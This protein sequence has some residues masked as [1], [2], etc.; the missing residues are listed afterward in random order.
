VTQ[1]LAAAVL[2]A[3]A[4]A[5]SDSLPESTL[6]V[7]TAA[8][9]ETWWE[10]HAAPARWTAPHPVVAGAL[11]L[12]SGAPGLQWGTLDLAGTGEARWTRLVVVMLD[13]ARHRFALEI[14]V[15][16]RRPAWR[17]AD[18]DSTA[19]LALNAGQFTDAVPWGWLVRG[20]REVLPPGHGPTSAAFAVDT[21]GAVHW[22]DSDGIAAARRRGDIA[23]AFQ[24]YPVLLREGAVPAQLRAAGRGIDVHHR[25]ARLAIGRRRD[26]RIVIVLTRFRGLGELLGFLPLGLTTPELAAVMGALGCDEAVALDGGTS[27]Q[28]RAAAGE[29]P[30]H[31]PGVRAVPLGLLAYPR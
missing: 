18:A 24:S 9:W 4:V 10:S 27:A 3:A 16:N 17:I 22:L 6:R 19:V 30:R 13:P 21:A 12:R 15:R 25:D 29:E 5:G 8:G 26:G 7:R 14:G 28:L 31:W 23:L 2:A 1:L 11:E 20:G